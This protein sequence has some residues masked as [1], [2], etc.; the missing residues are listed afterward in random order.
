MATPLALVDCNNFYASCE[1]L[2]QPALRGK[3]VVVLSNNDGCVIARSNEAKALGIPMGAPWHLHREQF[4][5]SGV[6]VR[7]S[8][9]TLYGDMSARVMRVLGG[10]TPDLEIYSIDEAFLRLAG[11]GDR[12]EGHARELRATVLQWTGIPVSVGIAPTKTLAKAANRM[13]KRDPESG[14]V[15]LLLTAEAQEAALARMALTDLWGVAGRMAQRMA[16]IGIHTP[17]D[18]RRADPRFVREKFSVVTER[19]VYELNGIPCLA[20]ED[21]TPDRK[22]I[23]ASR[24]FGQPVTR[25]SDMEEAVAAYTA[26]A[27][28]KMRRQN[29]AT[30]NLQVFVQTNNFRTEERQYFATQPV[31]LPVATADTGK[32]TRAALSGLGAIWKPGYRYKKAGVVFLDLQPAGEVLGGLFD[33][34]DTPAKRRLMSVVD[35]LNSHYGRDTITYAASGRHRS[36]KLRSD[37]L[38]GRFTTNWDELLKV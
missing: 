21:V 25:R 6:V 18:L 5:R 30:A 8:N 22:S 32:L 1:R 19:L 4:R 2:F 37:Q 29:L 31:Q 15:A 17:L 16:E 26:R 38:S 10:F 3:P 12:L 11:F 28:E 9:Y 34:P 23:M 14:G 27:A 33:A 36:W 35:K 20:L 24:S 13:A 7:S